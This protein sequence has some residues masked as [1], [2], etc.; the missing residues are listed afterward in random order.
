MELFSPTNQP[1]MKCQK[2]QLHNSFESSILD[3]DVRYSIIV[4]NVTVRVLRDI[5]KAFAMFFD[6]FLYIQFGVY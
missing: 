3:E 5:F 4:E 1:G 6:V 2:I